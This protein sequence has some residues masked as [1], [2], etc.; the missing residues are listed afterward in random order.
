MKQSN[1]SSVNMPKTL[2]GFY[3]KKCFPGLYKWIVL[4]LVLRLLE[5]SG[6]VVF[7]FVDRWIVAMFEGAP[8]GSAIY[9]H[10][11]PTIVLLI[12]INMGYTTIA[13]MRDHISSILRPYM[14]K[15]ISSVMCIY[16]QCLSGLTVWRGQ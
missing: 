3:F 12:G 8:L 11:M 4:Y 1:Y 2:L 13:I 16:S 14:G 9:H 7:P 6:S 5:Y 10:V 15:R